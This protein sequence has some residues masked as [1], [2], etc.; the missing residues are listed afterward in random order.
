MYK[1][2]HVGT[3]RRLPGTP[4][5]FRL[6]IVLCVRSVSLM[7]ANS[8]T[9]SVLGSSIRRQSPPELSQ[10]RACYG[11]DLSRDRFLVLE[12]LASSMLLKMFGVSLLL[13]PQ[14]RLPGYLDL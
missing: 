13:F 2:K 12:L 1:S 5:V 10:G 9:H 14:A 8:V 4:I 11:L 7:D 6:E 3:F